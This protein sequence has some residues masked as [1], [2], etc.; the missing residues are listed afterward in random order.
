[1]VTSSKSY[2][3]IREAADEL[4]RE[5]FSDQWQDH[6]NEPLDRLFPA[7]WLDEFQDEATRCLF[8]NRSEA[9]KHSKERVGQPP[10]SS[11]RLLV[12]RCMPKADY[13][14]P[15]AVR[16]ARENEPRWDEMAGLRW[17]D[18]DDGWRKRI[19]EQVT[20]SRPALEQWKTKHWSD[21]SRP[22]GRR[23]RQR[24]AARR[25]LDTL[26][27]KGIPNKPWKTIT[28]EVCSWLIDNQETPVGP[29]TVRRA[30]NRR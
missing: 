23:R 4:A 15:D 30:A 28:A 25:A 7:I 16:N 13:W 2:L 24:D 20:I 17:D 19:I 3:T 22:R 8:S 27:P 26:Y 14:T 9:E 29:D 12:Y 1:M 18:Y 10:G 6:R 11:T 5:R 21:E